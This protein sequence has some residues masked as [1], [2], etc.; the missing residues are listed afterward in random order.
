MIN[1]F[2]VLYEIW[3]V[4][5]DD[6]FNSLVQL[7]FI[8]V[9]GSILGGAILSITSFHRYIA[10]KKEFDIDHIWG[11]LLAPILNIVVGLIVY[12]LLQSG[13]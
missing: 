3:N 11:Y 9:I 6:G 12:A 1:D 7:A 5:P 8:T 10:I 2:A 13:Y 4:N